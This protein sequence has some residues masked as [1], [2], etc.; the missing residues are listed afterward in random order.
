MC[1]RDRLYTCNVGD[2]RAIAGVGSGE[3]PKPVQLTVDHTASNPKEKQRILSS[4]GRIVKKRIY[5]M[6]S[7]LPGLIPSRS[8]GDLMGCKAGVVCQPDVSVYTISEEY[9]FIAIM[10]DGVWENVA[11]AH[12]AKHVVLSDTLS[13]A[14]REVVKDAERAIHAGNRYRDDMT[15]ILVEFH[16]FGADKRVSSSEPEIEDD[17][18]TNPD[19]PVTFAISICQELI[20]QGVHPEDA[21]DAIM[22]LT[23]QQRVEVV[24]AINPENSLAAQPGAVASEKKASAEGETVL[25]NPEE[26]GGWFKGR[27]A[28]TY[29]E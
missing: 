29:R 19:D 25:A 4:R 26:A 5:M 10:S 9:R 2:S 15:A 27:A 8:F 7:N 14:A 6:D 23:P 17:Y 13:V 21:P 16:G 18:L 3:L 24:D 28:P 20:S 1:I 11:A 12:V 22:G